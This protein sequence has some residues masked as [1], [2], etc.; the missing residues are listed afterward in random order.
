MADDEHHHDDD[1]V[2]H[3]DVIGPQSR[4]YLAHL[5]LRNATFLQTP[6][7]PP[8][9]HSPMRPT[10]FSCLCPPFTPSSHY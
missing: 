10:L 9:R 4:I 8:S 6:K 7:L 1:V 2:D 5:Q 3:L